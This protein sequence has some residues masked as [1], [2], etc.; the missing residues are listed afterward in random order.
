MDSLCEIPFMRL[1][2]LSDL[3]GSPH[4]HAV[5]LAITSTAAIEALIA[6]WA[7]TSRRHWFWRAMAV[8]AGI[9]VLLP[10]GAYHPALAFAISSPLTIALIRAIQFRSRV[11]ATDIPADA[12]R[13]AF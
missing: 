6:I 11:K 4:F 7:A 9:V 10:I 13:G 2:I 1:P 12:P 3:L 8:W 5:C